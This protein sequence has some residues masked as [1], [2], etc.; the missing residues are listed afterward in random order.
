M[1]STVTCLAS[2]HQ[3]TQCCSLPQ[4]LCDFSV[5]KSLQPCLFDPGDGVIGVAGKE[6]A[7][8]K[9]Q[10]CDIRLPCNVSNLW[11]FMFSLLLFLLS[12]RIES[13][14]M[15]TRSA[16]RKNGSIISSWRFVNS[17]I[18]CSSKSNNHRCMVI[19]LQTFH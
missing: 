6:E 12:Q 9:V 11:A 3:K 15:R 14:R 18:S 7:N 4:T 13:V 19:R 8:K 1:V 5:K 16:A 17:R 10:N 2:N